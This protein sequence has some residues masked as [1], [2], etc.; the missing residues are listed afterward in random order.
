M[1]NLFNIAINSFRESLREPVFYLMLAAA[2]L[3]I[4]HYPS[5]SIF[6]FSEQMKLVVDSSMATSLIFSLIIAVLAASHTLG[7][8]MRNGTVLLLMSKPVFRWSFVLGKIFGIVSA[9]SL[10]ALICNCAAIISVYMATDQFRFDM[11]I[12]YSFGGVLIAGALVGMGANFWR[13]ASF[14]EIAT[15]ATSLFI[16]IFAIIC[17][18]TQPAPE[19]IL[20]RDLCLALI[21]VNFAVA[22]MATI[23]VVVATRAD[24]VQNLCICT[25]IF[26]LGLVSNYLFQRNT[27]SEILNLIFNTL[28][29]II[30]NW[31]F[32]WL[33]DAVA[34]N[35]PIPISYVITAATY[36]VIYIVIASMWAVA[37]FQNKELAADSR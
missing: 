5:A 23:S 29:A 12:Y 24:V 1:F 14:P 26:F 9:A 16:I 8:E 13:G 37:I 36:V 32:F 15:Y 19:G 35:R 21:L 30:P 22:A 20:V 34:I 25:V 11:G 33:A 2:L 10:F 28:Y 17:P 4:G 6:V 18:L 3:L 31:Q 27:D 7:Q